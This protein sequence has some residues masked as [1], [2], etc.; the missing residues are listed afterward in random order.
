MLKN[1]IISFLFT[2]LGIFSYSQKGVTTFGF[3]YKP[4]LPVEFLTVEKLALTNNDFSATV[5]QKFGNNFGAVIRWGFTNSL[6]LETGLNYIKRNF[7]METNVVSSGTSS[8]GSFGI[9]GY[10]I[11]I[12][13]LI[14]VQINRNSFLNVATGISTN[15]IASNV[16]SETDDKN[17]YQITYTKKMNL[18]YIA[19]IGY[20]YRTDKSGYFYVGVSLTNPF[21]SIGLIDVIYDE[22]NQTNQTITGKL[23]GN[24][25]SLDLRYFFNETKKVKTTQP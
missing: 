18:A 7:E 6:S 17:F 25:I 5:T 15:W 20:E 23:S 19:N 24:Y 8:K 11:P 12:Q 16:G 1:I 4:I 22:Y 9:T 13:G 10:E 14:N 21:H 2:L 3:Q